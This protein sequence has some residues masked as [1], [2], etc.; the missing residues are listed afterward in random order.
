MTIVDLL[1]DLRNLGVK[2][3]LEE[4]RLRYSAPEKSL[5]P[6][7]RARLVERKAEI[8]AFLREAATAVRSG[9]P[10]LLPV[11]RDGKLPLS[12]AQQRMWVLDQL[13]PGD[14]RYNIPLSV[15]IR[16]RLQVAALRESLREIT[17]RHEVMRTTFPNLDG[18]PVQIISRDTL[19]DA[20]L[21]DLSELS[22]SDREAQTR[23]L[24]TEEASRPF[25]LARGPLLRASLLRLGDDDHVLLLSMHHI[26]SDGW[27]M[28]VFVEEF[29]KLYEAFTR[30]N[31]SPLAE[32]PVQYADFASW[33]RQWLQGEVL[34][35]QLSYWKQRLAGSPPVLELPTDRPR[36]AVQTFQ[37][38]VK[39]LALPHELSQALKDLSRQEEATLF[40]TLLAAF[41]ALL[42]R[43][44][45]QED[46]V[47]GCPIANRTRPETERMIGF[48][49]NTLV[50]RAD[51]SGDPGF[52]DLLRQTREAALGAY[53]HRDLP[54]EHLVDELKLE[55]NLSYTPLFQVAFQLQTARREAFDLPGLTLR[56]LEIKS[57]TAKFDLALSL[58]EGADKVRGSLE[59]NTDLFD[60]A[61]ITRMVTAFRTLLEGVVADPERRLS[62]LPIISGSEQHRLLVEWND[63]STDYPK[64][65]CIHE[66]FEAQ[67]KQR[68][69]AVA[70][71]FAGE[72]LSY[73]ALNQRAN[74]LAHHLRRLGVGPE[75]VV[76]ICTERSLEMIVGL[77]GILKAGG[78]YLPM[79]P[80]YPRER[81]AFMLEDARLPILLTQQRLVEAL[82]ISDG[83]TER[84]REGE[85][86]RRRDR[87]TERQREGETERQ[88]DRETERQRE[89]EKERRRDRGN[90]TTSPSLR[91]SVSPSLRLR[92]RLPS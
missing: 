90:P 82:G 69:D 72:Q 39:T 11:P 25:D 81:L 60:E 2:L 51:F 31:R 33:E 67:V 38:A 43:Y 7:L 15:R 57:E 14:S 8:I 37:G 45:R 22:G 35:R 27:S 26:I 48:F 24:A 62:S 29:A 42:Y 23:R 36:P 28:G 88:R 52:R 65:R 54:F 16:G 3:W 73:R 53:A 10:P 40:M 17:R 56:P 19:P 92:L 12:F 30:G 78:A 84:Q 46:I 85:T 76:G 55:R 6:T 34:E 47:V 44:T 89:G 71:C 41:Q 13:A 59:Y 79:D 68:P 18:Y 4:D 66:L 49:I 86:E 87:E 9:P 83:E 64:R 21:I 1:S 70:A 58:V 32:L 75:V 91:L 50:M 80:A 77:L 63:T 5:T 20:P 74:Q 61:T